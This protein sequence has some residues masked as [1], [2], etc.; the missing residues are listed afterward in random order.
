[1]DRLLWK[2]VHGWASPPPPAGPGAEG[3]GRVLPSG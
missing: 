2:S 3:E 1:M